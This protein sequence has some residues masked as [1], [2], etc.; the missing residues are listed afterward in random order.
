[1]HEMS[2]QLQRLQHQGSFPPPPSV[3]PQS[4]LSYGPGPHF[5]NTID[6]PNELPRTLPPLVNGAMQGIQYSDDRR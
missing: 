1:M 5:A 4:P 6:G 2:Q 3:N